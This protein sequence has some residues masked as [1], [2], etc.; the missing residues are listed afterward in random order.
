MDKMHKFAVRKPWENA[1]SIKDQGFGLVGLSSEKDSSLVRRLVSISESS[2][3][4]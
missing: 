2:G 3:M 1:K 4:G